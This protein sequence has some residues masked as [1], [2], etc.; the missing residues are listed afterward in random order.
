MKLAAKKATN[1]Q[2]LCT[3]FGDGTWDKQ[4][5]AELGYN[6]VLVGSKFKHKPSIV[7]FKSTKSALA[8]IGLE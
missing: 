3:Y 7:N 2:L 5:C 6:F 1:S 4:A 8:C